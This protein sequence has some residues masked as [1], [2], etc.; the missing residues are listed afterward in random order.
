MRFDPVSFGGDVQDAT[1]E[2]QDRI[3]NFSNTTYLIKVKSHVT[4]WPGLPFSI[5]L[6][7][8]L[9]G[10]P[11]SPQKQQQLFAFASV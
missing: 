1:T 7:H 3:N 4:G 8:N 6:L 10:R 2:L 5:R 11:F 9:S